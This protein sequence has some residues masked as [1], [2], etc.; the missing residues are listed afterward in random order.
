MAHATTGPAHG[1]AEILLRTSR[2]MALEVPRAARGNARAVHRARVASRRLREALPIAGA[3]APHEG[4]TRVRREVRA[5]TRAFGPVREVD[6]SLAVLY[7]AAERHGGK[8]AAIAEVERRLEAER[9]NE[10]RRM[11]ARLDRSDV[12]R[13]AAR[14][15]A[16]AAAVACAP[17]QWTWRRALA[18]RLRRRAG[19]L[20]EAL[21]ASGTLYVPE[22]L[23]AVRIATKKLRYTLELAHEAAGVPVEDLMSVAKDTQDRLGA[24]L[25]RHVLARRLRKV[26]A[27]TRGRVTAA[28][29]AD[30][31]AALERD[32]RMRYADFLGQV[33]ALT[34]IARR[35]A[36]D[37]ARAVAGPRPSMIK[38]RAAE[39]PDLGKRAPAADGKGSHPA[40]RAK[41]RAGGSI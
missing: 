22:Q 10:R 25:D 39:A 24:L 6:V 23:H 20:N 13:L 28:R 1:L 12:T 21:A 34:D 36:P 31:A 7:E 40:G 16:I 33:A 2:T 30:L 35:A 38:V 32:C 4:A 37:A 26:A 5:I 18:A 3:A 9:A 11:R 19:R 17:G 29:V 14:C 27:E 41:L 8:A 15:Q